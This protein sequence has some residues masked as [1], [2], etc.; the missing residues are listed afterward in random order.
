MT[1]GSQTANT[2]VNLTVTEPTLALTSVLNQ[3][4]GI[5]SSLSTDDITYLDLLGN[6]DSKLDVSDFLGWVNHNQ[7]SPAPP[8]R[9]AVQAAALQG[10]AAP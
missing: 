9:Q 1:S 8:A 10:R 3:L 5:S 2:T 7:I 6:N 4:L